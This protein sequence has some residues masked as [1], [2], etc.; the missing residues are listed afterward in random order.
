MCDCQAA[1]Y[2]HFGARAAI[3]RR[4]EVRK[5]K[6]E[7]VARVDQMLDQY[8]DREIAAIL[9]REGCRTS[10]GLLFNTKKSPSSAPLTSCRADTSGYA[11]AACSQPVRSQQSSASRE[12]PST[13]GGARTHHE[14]LC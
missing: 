1:S 13:N 11:A 7:V 2:P 14:V 10:E 4:Q 3:A 9:N 8:C 6:P 5:F 12:P